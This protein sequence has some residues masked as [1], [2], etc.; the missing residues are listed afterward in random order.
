MIVVLTFIIITIFIF[1]NPLYY[2]MSLLIVSLLVLSYL[3]LHTYLTFL[4]AFILVIVYVGAI[5]ILIGYICAISPNLSVEPDYSVVYYFLISLP[6]FF[7]FNYLDFSY[8]STTTFTIVDY[9]YSYQGVFI[10]FILIIILFV[11]L[12]IVTT[13]YSVPKGPFR[14]VTV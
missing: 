3:A 6:L 7:L 12:L 9:F 10:F 13:Q 11:T 1:K 8:F 5:M 2:T 14:S 4:T